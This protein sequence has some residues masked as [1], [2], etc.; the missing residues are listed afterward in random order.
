MALM[1]LDHVS[2]PLK[3]TPRLDA[4][5][6][7]LILFLLIIISGI[8]NALLVLESRKH[9]DLEGFIQ[10]PLALAQLSI[11]RKSA[12]IESILSLIFSI[13]VLF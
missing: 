4:D 12:L 13:I 6:T 11:F 5:S 2:R 3:I 8:L 9:L 7:K 10:S 1:W